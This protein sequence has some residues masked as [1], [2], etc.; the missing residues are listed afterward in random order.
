MSNISLPNPENFSEIPAPP[1]LKPG[2]YPSTYNGAVT[3][4]SLPYSPLLGPGFERLCYLLLL[5]Q[6]YVPRYFGNPGDSQFGI[7]LIVQSDGKHVV[8]QCKNEQSFPI[9]KMEKALTKFEKE[10]LQQS[11]LPKPDKF[12]LCCPLPLRDLRTNEKWTKLEEEF[13]ARTGVE[14]ESWDQHFLDE[15]LKFLPDLVAEIF[16]PQLAEQFCEM[17]DWMHDLFRPVISTSSDKFIE[18]YFERKQAERIYLDEEEA[19]SFEEKLER[20][21][22]VL[23]KG[24]PGSGKSITSL[25]WAERLDK[26]RVYYTNLH[27]DI[28]DNDLVK[29]I[30]RRLTRPTIF[31]LDDCQGR[32]EAVN[33]VWNRV[34]AILEGQ[35]AK[36][37]LVFLTRSVPTP[38]GMVRGDSAEVVEIE[39]ALEQDDAIVELQPDLQIFRQIIT[40][41]R[42]ELAGISEKRLKRVFEFTGHDLLLLDELLEVLDEPTK[43]DDLKPEYLFQEV[44]LKYFGSRT[45]AR[46]CFMKLAA[47][48][49][50]DLTPRVL[51]FN[52]NLKEEI[53]RDTNRESSKAVLDMVIQA[54]NPPRYFFLHSSAA[55][56]VFRAL[57]WISSI[58]DHRKKTVDYLIDFFRDRNADDEQL[59]IDLSNILKNQLKL[60][61]DQFEL[62]LLRS[63]FL[64]DPGIFALFESAFERLPLNLLS[65]CLFSLKSTSSS[66][67]KNY[68]QLTQHK[69]KDETVLNLV[70]TRPF[71][72]LNSF[73]ETLGNHFPSLLLMLKEQ[74]INLGLP[75][76]SKKLE[77]QNFLQLLS[78]LAEPGELAWSMSLKLISDQDIERM[79]QHTVESGSLIG[80]LALALRRLG[81]RN[82]ELLKELEGKIGVSRFL[83]LIAK[84]GTLFE[85]FHLI[86][87]TSP[88][89]AKEMIATLDELYVVALTNKTINS[90][91]SI[92]TLNLALWELGKRNP[93]LLKELEGK[94][95]VSRFLELIAK[96]GTLFELFHLIQYTSP[97]TAKE[98]IATLDEPYILQLIAKTIDSH[99]AIGSLHWTLKYLKRIDENS[100]KR[101]ERKIGAKQWWHLIF[102][103]GTPGILAQI[104][105]A[106]TREYQNEMAKAAKQL[107]SDRWK[108]F[109]LQGSFADL[110]YLVQEAPFFFY[111]RFIA[112]YRLYR[113]TFVEL[114]QRGSWEEL[115]TGWLK[116]SEAPDAPPNKYLIDLLERN[117][118]VI[119]PMSLQFSSF[120][121]ATH[122]VNLLWRL[123][124]TKRNALNML[125]RNFLKSRTNYYA[126]ENFLRCSRLLFHTLADP[127]A[128]P[129]TARLILKI[130]NT[131]DVSD[132]CT[133]ATSLDLFLYLWNL[134]ELWFQWK[135]PEENSFINFLSPD[136]D[137]A[138]YWALQERF[139]EKGN[140]NE[141]DNLISLTGLLSFQK[142]ELEYSPEVETFRTTLPDFDRMVGKVEYKTFIPGVFFLL[143]LEWIYQKD[144]E[145]DP[146]IWSKL[147]QK[148]D[149]YTEKRGALYNLCKNVR[150]W[151]NY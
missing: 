146:S 84:N 21:R 72:E 147:L 46:P 103:N 26:Y 4:G 129:E 12:V 79:T 89:T 32:I 63:N 15:T 70:F 78:I 77:L 122:C 105:V 16:S 73:L 94:I 40:L 1:H 76:P 58:K 95:G 139:A 27:N 112:D 88:E 18:H 56:L 85:L 45:V 143:G 90:G 107:S 74:V 102:S 116:I 151:I 37:M 59:A 33:R 113:E 96:N 140:L 6:G 43:I 71:S 10:W 75:S 3:L 68:E 11:E 80:T 126:D 67:F 69:I 131:E 125:L 81:K 93:E 132:F 138:V 100:Q 123:F 7:D 111:R 109:F 142:M 121:E 29:G 104:L 118:R 2:F 136:I 130:G 60:T 92:G 30:K 14:I 61:D 150:S 137:D 117:L 57:I 53:E 108:D 64:E 41:V 28:S 39:E 133:D 9:G 141:K 19:Y 91:R 13:Y 62:R 99:R 144:Q 51:E 25:A 20:N 48:A 101:L 145:I 120:A 50:F 31:I 134:Y 83:E 110:C 149:N 115:N 42:P 114:I 97:E 17:D 44:L 47:L 87:Y 52:C 8:Y 65:I 55:E 23:I 148:A 22:S 54:G 38:E 106:M 35:T 36:G 86:Q 98:M 82:P 119:Q 34:K 24:L 135:K 5:R 124:P 66:Y 128:Q 49:Q 127:S